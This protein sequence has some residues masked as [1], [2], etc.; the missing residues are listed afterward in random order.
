ML[1]SL[2]MK[3]NGKIAHKYSEA[4]NWVRSALL[5][6]PPGGALPGLREMVKLTG[7]GRTIL[8]RVLA[9]AEANN[10]IQRRPRSGYYRAEPDNCR[11][12]ELAVLLDNSNGQLNLVGALPQ[13]AS[14]I[15]RIV[16]R[17]QELAVENRKNLF[18]TDDPEVL[19]PDMPLFL[20]GAVSRDLLHR[21]QKKS[22]RVV[23]ISGTRSC[24]LQVMPPKEKNVRSALEYL[25]KLGHKRMGLFFNRNSDDGDRYDANGYLFEYYKFMAEQGIKVY[26]H[27]LLALDSEKEIT[28]QLL[29][30]LRHEVRP[31]SLIVP[32]CWLPTVYRVFE[33]EKVL[34]P[35][36]ISIL[37]TGTPA[38]EIYSKY[39]PATLWDH[40]QSVA[41][42]AWELMFSGNS[43]AFIRLEPQ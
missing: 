25:H 20:A 27:F 21:V 42:K 40:P 18:I 22:L 14:Y 32:Y 38:D 26:P 16:L 15:S 9:E 6:L 10:Y 23:A 19:P 37:A 24:E 11:S 1:Y 8:E 7:I 41:D 39:S 31:D 29:A 3:E 33:D 30:A 17:L 5:L 2:G 13:K 35:W 28:E 36:H 12:A 43:R 4:R 34:V